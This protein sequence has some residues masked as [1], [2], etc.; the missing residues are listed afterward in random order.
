MKRLFKKNPAKR[1]YKLAR[2]LLAQQKQES[3]DN[4]PTV[5]DL[6]QFKEKTGH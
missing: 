3:D 2:Q 4:G 1:S 5:L 6:G